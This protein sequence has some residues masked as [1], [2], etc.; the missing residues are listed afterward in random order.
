LADV[1]DLPTLQA[2]LGK[3]QSEFVRD[4]IVD[5]MRIIRLEEEE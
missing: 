1:R 5:T 4:E 3:E 2:I